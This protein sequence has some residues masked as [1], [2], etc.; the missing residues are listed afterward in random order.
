MEIEY[1]LLQ[2]KYFEGYTSK[3][4]NMIGSYTFIKDELAFIFSLNKKKKYILLKIIFKVMVFVVIQIILLL[5]EEMMFIFRMNVQQIII[6]KM[7]LEI[8]ILKIQ[9]NIMN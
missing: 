3:Q 4:C 6:Q 8:V 9:V 7:I 1:Q 2:K 5:V